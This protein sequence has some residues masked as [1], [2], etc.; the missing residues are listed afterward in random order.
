MHIFQGRRLGGDV[1]LDGNRFIDCEFDDCCLHYRGGEIPVF[2][3]CIFKRFKLTIHDSAQRTVEFFSKI[4]RHLP[5]VG[6]GIV[7]QMFDDIRGVF[8]QPAPMPGHT[9]LPSGA[10]PPNI[11]GASPVQAIA[12]VPKQKVA[13]IDPKHIYLIAIASQT[14]GWL[15]IERISGGASLP[16]GK[17]SV[18][19]KTI[20]DD[21]LLATVNMLYGFSLESFLKCLLYLSGTK[22]PN[23]H[24]TDRLFKLL[25]PAI[26]KEIRDSYAEMVAANSM[27]TEIKREN[28]TVDFSFDKVMAASTSAFED[29]RY[30]YESVVT[31]VPS[32]QAVEVLEAV[33]LVIVRLHPE[34]SQPTSPPC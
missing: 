22:P 8:R 11:P 7:E 17:T 5:P 9:A 33:R 13:Q 10:P 3:R 29:Y 15:L 16:A 25:P 30:L 2:D 18:F 27:Y 21:Y 34:F 6:P 20:D 19:N 32:F 14:A 23:I 1:E 28:P 26:Q 24:K 12:A 4:Y 31:T